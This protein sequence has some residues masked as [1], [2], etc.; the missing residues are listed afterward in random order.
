MR[1]RVVLGLIDGAKQDASLVA[2]RGHARAE[3]EVAIDEQRQPHIFQVRRYE[4]SPRQREAA[5]RRELFEFTAGIFGDERDART[6]IAE[7]ARAISRFELR[8]YDEA[9]LTFEM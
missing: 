4:G 5:R 9:S 7:R 3:L 8:A 6:G 1:K 2:E